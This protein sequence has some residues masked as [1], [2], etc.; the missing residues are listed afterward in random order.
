MHGKVR[1]RLVAA[2]ITSALAALALSAPTAAAQ[3]PPGKG[4]AE[5][6]VVTCDGQTVTVVTPLLGRTGWLDGQHAVLQAVTVTGPEGTETR[7]FGNK[8]G[9]GRTLTCV[10]SLGP[11]TFTY[12]A[13]L[14]P[15]R[16]G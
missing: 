14:V 9:L 10:E 15:P 13:A 4:L 11:Y 6:F 3:T 5:S 2:G 16:D 7:T 8:T 1:S 12:V